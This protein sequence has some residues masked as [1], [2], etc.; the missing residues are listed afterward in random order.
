MA[1]GGQE[2]KA[3]VVVVESKEWYMAAY[4]PDGIPSSKHLKL[5]TVAVLLSA[6]SIPEGYVIIETLLISIDPYL[7]SR[8]T[9]R[10]EG[11]YFPQFN[12]NEVIPCK[13]LLIIFTIILSEI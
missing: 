11:L 5:R 2:E 4:A 1:C 10:D 9:G 8:M 13:L 6:D 12:L 7:R 3:G